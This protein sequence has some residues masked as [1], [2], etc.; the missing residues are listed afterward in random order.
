MKTRPPFLD[1]HL[2]RYDVESLALIGIAVGSLAGL[3]LIWWLT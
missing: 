2:T 3:A 1:H